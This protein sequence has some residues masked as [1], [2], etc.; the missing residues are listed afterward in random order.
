MNLF[1][2]I[3]NRFINK[4]SIYVKPEPVF[5]NIPTLEQEQPYKVIKEFIDYDKDVHAVG[6]T[7]IYKG[8]AFLPYEDGLS[9]FVSKNDSLIMYRLQW[10]KEEQAD[11]IDNFK[12][13]VERC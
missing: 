11:V 12:D 4:Q 3:F 9:L 1:Q 13:Y 5:G 7:W 10:R 6:E 2:K 8:T